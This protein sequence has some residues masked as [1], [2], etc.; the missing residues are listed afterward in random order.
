MKQQTDEEFVYSNLGDEIYLSSVKIGDQVWRG[1]MYSSLPESPFSYAQALAAEAK[2]PSIMDL[3]RRNWKNFH[4]RNI[5]L[6]SHF[7][8]DIIT[9]P[10]LPVLKILEYERTGELN[11]PFQNNSFET[12]L[13][14]I[15]NIFNVCPFEILFADSAGLEAMFLTPVSRSHAEYFQ[16]VIY[17]ISLDSVNLMFHELY[18]NEMVEDSDERMSTIVVDYILHKQTLRLYWD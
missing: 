10:H 8:V 1:W 6:W 4:N 7:G 18:K 9:V 12:I 13:E 11:A 17:S 2:K 15:S 3:I 16:E 5:R 14:G